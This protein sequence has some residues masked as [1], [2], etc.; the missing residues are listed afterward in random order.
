MD[1]FYINVYGLS[2][3]MKT[4]F[5]LFLLFQV[6]IAPESGKDIY[7]FLKM[8]ANLLQDADQAKMYLIFFP[9][10]AAAVADKVLVIKMFG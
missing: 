7:F 5:F 6:V 1:P 2:L 9:P 4:S 8:R 10:A 3:V